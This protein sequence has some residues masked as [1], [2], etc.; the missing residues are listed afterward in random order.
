VKYPLT[1]PDC[2][3]FLRNEDLVAEANRCACDFSNISKALESAANEQEAV[4]ILGHA[5]KIHRATF[6]GF[7]YGADHVRQQIKDGL[8]EPSDFL[9]SDGEPASAEAAAMIANRK[10]K[11]WVE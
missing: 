6:D 9:N 1:T 8:F 5:Q 10:I 3:V 7:I 4:V 2:P 11:E